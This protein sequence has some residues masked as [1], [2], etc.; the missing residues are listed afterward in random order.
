MKTRSSELTLSRRHRE[1]AT[2]LSIV[3][4]KIHAGENDKE[5]DAPRLV[6]QS[7]PDPWIDEAMKG[8]DPGE[9]RHEVQR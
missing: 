7:R 9:H 4:E 5:D 3:V 6:K 1:L 8:I 2:R